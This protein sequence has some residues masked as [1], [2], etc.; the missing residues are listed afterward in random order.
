MAIIRIHNITFHRTG[1]CRRCG[2]CENKP[3]PCTHFKMVEGKATCDTY[4]TGDY[5]EKRCNVFPDN[6]FCRVV[7]NGVCGFEFVPVT[8]ADAKRYKEAKKKWRLPI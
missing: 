3:K 1:E 4:G 5:L 8:K 2:E 7:L 6:P